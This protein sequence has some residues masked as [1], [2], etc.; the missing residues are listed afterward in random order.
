ML[1]FQPV[2]L[3]PGVSLVPDVLLILVCARNLLKMGRKVAKEQADI[4]NAGSTQ[5]QRITL[6]RYCVD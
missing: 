5:L 6:E 4:A 1:N 2:H 3:Y